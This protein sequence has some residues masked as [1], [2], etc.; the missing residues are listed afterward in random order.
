MT[1]ASL[2]LPADALAF[3]LTPDSPLTIERWTM[4]GGSRP[5]TFAIEDT[6]NCDGYWIVRISPEPCT[7]PGELHAIHPEDI[8][9]ALESGAALGAEFY[10]TDSPM[11]RADA[12]IRMLPGD[13]LPELAERIEAESSPCAGCGAP[14]RCEDSGYIHRD[15]EPRCGLHPSPAGPS[16][17]TVRGLSSVLAFGDV[18]EYDRGELEDLESRMARWTMRDRAEWESACRWIER[19]NA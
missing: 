16:P 18:R 10:L 7:A 3:A 17:E 8:R 1:N 4:N 6:R 15:P 9:E 11:E 14:I 12:E 5:D 19:L 2:T 13:G